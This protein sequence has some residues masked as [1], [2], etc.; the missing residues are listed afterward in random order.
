MH[1]FWPAKISFIWASLWPAERKNYNDKV[2][3][4]KD[5]MGGCWLVRL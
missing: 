4:K 2:G 5:W 3:D 1:F